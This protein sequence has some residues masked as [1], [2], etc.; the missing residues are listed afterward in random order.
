[1]RASLYNQS[2]SSWLKD[3]GTNSFHVCLRSDFSQVGVLLSEEV[4]E[5]E[6]GLGVRNAGGLKVLKH[7]YSGLLKDRLLAL[8]SLLLQV[9]L[10]L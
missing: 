9:R 2:F 5:R 8:L 1:M 3:L 4:S 6:L 10:I 7:L